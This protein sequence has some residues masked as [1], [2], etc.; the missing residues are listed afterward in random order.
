MDEPTNTENVSVV[1]NCTVQSPTCES[2]GPNKVPTRDTTT[3]ETTIR[4]ELETQEYK[5]R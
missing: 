4:V 2:Q 5:H 3:Q 1:R